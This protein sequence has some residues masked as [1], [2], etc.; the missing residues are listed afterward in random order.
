MLMIMS[1]AWSNVLAALAVV[2]LPLGG[3][4]IAPML[5]VSTKRLFFTLNTWG[6]PFLIGQITQRDERGSLWV[7]YHLLDLAYVPWG[8]A[9]VILLLSVGV[10]MTGRPMSDAALYT[11]SFAAVLLFGYG[12]ELWDTLVS[13]Y[14]GYSLQRA[15]DVG[16]YTTITVGALATMAIY[17]W[18]RRPSARE[19][20]C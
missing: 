2:A 9:L 19:A 20:A 10:H 11:S 4:W 3:M 8:T 17:L 13:W 6:I 7:Q 18:C 12:S 15:A 5:A 14:A 16:D 1:F